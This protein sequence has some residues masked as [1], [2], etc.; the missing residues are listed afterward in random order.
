[1]LWGNTKANPLPPMIH[2]QPLSATIADGLW[3]P[4]SHLEITIKI[5][6]IPELKWLR[7]RFYIGFHFSLL[8]LKI[9]E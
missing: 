5:L 8:V 3:L 2:E 1:M 7:A 6:V 9:H 4:R